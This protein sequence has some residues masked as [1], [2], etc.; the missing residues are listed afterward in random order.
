MRR[1]Q[2][3]KMT[4]KQKALVKAVVLDPSASLTEL[5]R[6]SGYAG[7]Q[8]VS[9]A[10][11]AEVVQDELAKC[12][13]IMDQREKLTIGALLT[14]IEEG[15]EATDVR[16]VKLDGTI[17]KVSA[18]VKD[19]NARHKFL[20]SALKLR[21]LEKSD[22]DAMPSGPV[23]VALILLGGGSEAEKTAVADVLIAARLSRGLHPIENRKMTEEEAAQY[24]RTA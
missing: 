19:F 17:F 9:R 3:K 11:K 23:N 18:E 5:G 20:T 15:L 2:R 14:H 8:Q 1:P 4:A 13:S 24:R 22:K 16:S 6:T 12:R 21:G 7:R 10:L